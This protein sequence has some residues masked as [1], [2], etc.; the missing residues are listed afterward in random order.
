MGF[1]ILNT[2][3]LQ[4]L[5]SKDLT[6]AAWC[7]I[8]YFCLTVTKQWTQTLRREVVYLGLGF[9]PKVAWLHV[10]GY[11]MAAEAYGIGLMFTLWLIRKHKELDRTWSGICP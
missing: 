9:Q 11:I 7:T 3:E 10:P 6:G 2:R 1:F 4:P 8:S 5:K